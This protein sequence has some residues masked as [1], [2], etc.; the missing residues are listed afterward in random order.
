MSGH[1]KWRS[2]ET[3]SIPKETPPEMIAYVKGYILA[4]EDVLKD[5]DESTNCCETYDSILFSVTNSLESARN[6]LE[7]LNAKQKR[8]DT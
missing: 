5:L 6:T 4:M 1:S 7:I 2:I 8:S 3:D